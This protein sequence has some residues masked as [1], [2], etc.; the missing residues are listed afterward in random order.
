MAT[1]DLN[2]RLRKIEEE[3]RQI[4][5]EIASGRK[6][7]PFVVFLRKVGKFLVSYWAPL[8]FAF[9]V[10]TIIY[11]KFAF[12]IDYFEEYR[13]KS[14][15]KQMS[16]Y[17]RELGDKMM[18]ASEWKAAE[19]SYK[20]A[21]EIDPNNAKATY[22]IL[23][24]RVFQPVEGQK[25][26]DPAVVDTKLGF[27]LSLFPDDR[28]VY[29]LEG[30]RC[31]DQQDIENAKKWFTRSIEKDSTST[32]AYVNIGYLDMGSYDA[33]RKEWFVDIRDAIDKFE[34]ALNID[35]NTPWANNNLGFCYLIR[36]DFPKAIDHLGKS[37]RINPNLLTAINLGDAYRFSGD[38]EAAIAWHENAKVNMSQPGIENESYAA[39]VWTY[40]FMPLEPGDT[41]N[42]RRYVKVYSMDEKKTFVHFALSFDYALVNDSVKA[43][44]EFNSALRLGAYKRFRSFFDNK[45]LAIQKFLK[46]DADVN[47]WFVVHRLLVLV[48]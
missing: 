20:R 23:K 24:S 18:A 10:G 40:N 9:A 33:I 16:E 4:K 27:L 17:Y 28:D 8:S 12:G 32:G 25:F 45:M 26:F 30:V 19:G 42:I 3:L 5:G 31:M 14:I 6:H 29:F 11:V 39:G 44:Q 36:A 15:T 7:G 47:R 13:N 35:P 43:Q 21:L 46:L 34:N 41:T 48:R 38:F 1:N 22:G 37:E 2:P